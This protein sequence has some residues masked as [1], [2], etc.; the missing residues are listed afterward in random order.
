MRCQKCGSVFSDD[1]VRCP[2][3]GAV[4]DGPRDQSKVKSLFPFLKSE[5][6]KRK[7][8]E[9]RAKIEIEKK[10]DELKHKREEKE[11]GFLRS[12]IGILDA[13]G[14]DIEE[15][16]DSRSLARFKKKQKKHLQYYYS[17]SSLARGICSFSN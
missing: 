17:N 2:K 5:K 6:E 7:E 10:I 3:C 15:K 1:L 16:L 8:E 13:I 14:D 9:L 12:N 11:D 4:A